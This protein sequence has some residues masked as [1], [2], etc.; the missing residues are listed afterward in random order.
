MEFRQWP[1]GKGTVFQPFSHGSNSIQPY[2]FFFSDL[3]IC[4]INNKK[5]IIGRQPRV[6]GSRP[7]PATIFPKIVKNSALRKRKVRQHLPV[8]NQTSSLRSVWRQYVGD[9]YAWRGQPEPL[10][11]THSRAGTAPFGSLPLRSGAVPASQCLILL[12][13]IRN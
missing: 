13:N 4:L 7:G 11:G 2:Q 1:S 3:K 8:S 5:I 12:K 6:W 9:V 10:R